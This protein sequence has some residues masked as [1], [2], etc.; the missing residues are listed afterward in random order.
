MCDICHEG[1]QVLGPFLKPMTHLVHTEYL[2]AGRTDRDVREVLRD[3]MYAATVTGSPVENACRLIK[4]YESEGRGYYGAA[5]AML[6]RDAEGGPVRRQPDRDPHRRR[7]PRR[8]AEGHRRSH[9]GAR[10]RSGLRGGRDARQGRRASSAPSGWCRPPP[11]ADGD[12][13][14]LVT[15]RGRAARAQRPQPAAEHVLADRPGR[16]AAGPAAGRQE[17]GD[18]R[19]RGRLREHAAPRARRARH[20]QPRSCATRT[21]RRAA[22][23]ASTWSSSGPGPGDPRDGDDPKMAQPAATRWRGCWPTSGRSWPSAWA[24]RRCAT[25]SGSRWPTR[26]SSSRAPSRRSI[27]DGRTERVGFYN[28]FVGRVADGDL[29]EGVARGGRRRDRRHPPAARAA[30]PRASSSTPSRSSPSTATTCCT[31][32]WSSLLLEDPSRPDPLQ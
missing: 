11:A 30:L 27:L 23:T 22:S 7:R 10:L 3:T 12:I 19:R 28:T 14:E 20:D 31:T 15:R 5:L 21:T 24:T 29:P 32:S 17:R 26:T 8:H 25:S 6:G 9:A 1:G 2:L 4:Q 13:A 16:R 18:P